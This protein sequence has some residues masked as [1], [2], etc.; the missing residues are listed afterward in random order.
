MLLQSL[1]LSMLAYPCPQG[2]DVLSLEN[3]VCQVANIEGLKVFK[4]GINVI[5]YV[6]LTIFKN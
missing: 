1:T 6:N 5:V 4:L 2:Q 3:E